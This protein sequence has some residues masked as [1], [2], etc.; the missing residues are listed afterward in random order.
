MINKKSPKKVT[1]SDAIGARS[2][3]KSQRNNI[4]QSLILICIGMFFFVVQLFSSS[5]HTDMEKSVIGYL[6]IG[7]LALAL[8][9]VIK[10]LVRRIRNVKGLI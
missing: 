2:M 9:I 3:N 1:N 5:I 7:L 4:I 6:S 10:I 8:L